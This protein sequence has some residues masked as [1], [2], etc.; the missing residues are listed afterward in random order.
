M[1]FDRGAGGFN[2]HADYHTTTPNF[3]DD[4][5]PGF[6]TAQKWVDM[7]Q[8]YPD[9][10]RLSN[11]QCENCHGPQSY[12]QVHPDLS[13]VDARVSLRSEVCGSCHGEPARHG[14]FQQWQL[15]NHADYDLARDRGAPSGT[16]AGSTNNCGRCHSGNGF[17][18]WS[19][20]N[21]DPNYL[22]DVTWDK[23]TVVPQTCPT[24]H[25]PHDTGT[26][27]GEITDARVR[28][29]AGEPG[30]CGDKF[31]DS[32]QLLASF[33]A[34]NVGKAA[35]CMTCHNSRADAPRTDSNWANLD[36]SQKES[37]PHH[38]V[39]A[40]L[41]MARNAYFFGDGELGDSGRGKHSLIPNVCVRCHMELSQEP[42]V[43]A[44]N[45]GGTNHTFAADPGICVEC[46]GNGVTAD[47]IDGL[48]STYLDQL[49]TALSDAW[50][51]LL[52]A[53]YS[54]G[55]KIKQITLPAA[56][57]GTANDVV[58]NS[59][60]PITDV[61]WVYSRGT[62]L[63]VTV[64]STTCSN[65]TVSGSSGIV[66]GK[67]ANNPKNTQYLEAVSLQPG[68]D[69]L[70]KAQWNYGLLY[71]DSGRGTA[72]RGVHNPDFSIKALTRATDMVNDLNP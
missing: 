67:I 22:L 64:G 65:L 20:H 24:C 40:D 10:A 37:S 23:D 16:T 34:I 27:S 70:W 2:D 68:N 44:Y 32:Y 28:V 11:I 50:M 56:R 18:Q 17:I 35:T 55:G 45:N 14:R 66:V 46:H 54:N 3:V 60:N 8:D 5:L 38:G 29:N 62:R 26:F 13:E 53:Q 57:C 72:A 39:Q 48:I 42:P 51:R 69:V 52:V 19:K 49:K 4:V 30:A 36:P 58:A 33:Q 7:L 43:T 25:N 12:N 21:F 31:C 59:D 71:E 61:E 63:N 6:G 15:S 1:G 9:L 41:I 47:N